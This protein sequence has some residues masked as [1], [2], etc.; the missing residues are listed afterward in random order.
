MMDFRELRVH[1][2]SNF[3][4]RL[5]FILE[6]LIEVLYAVSF[7]DSSD[8]EHVAG[9]HRGAAVVN[10]LGDDLAGGLEQNVSSAHLRSHRRIA[11]QARGTD[12]V[13]FA[14]VLENNPQCPLSI[15]LIAVRVD[16]KGVSLCLRIQVWQK[17]RIIE[18]NVDVDSHGDRSGASGLYRPQ[19]SNCRS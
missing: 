16:V 18:E 15:G 9:L 12:K 6:G 8:V 11:G 2:A 4:R 1:L 3:Q 7:H 5:A 19:K 14:N 13:D 10:L 17:L